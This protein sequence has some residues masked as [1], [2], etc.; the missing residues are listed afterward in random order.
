MLIFIETHKTCDF[1]GG[2]GPDPLSPP[3][4]KHLDEQAFSK[5]DVPIFFFYFSTK[6]Y[7]LGTLLSTQNIC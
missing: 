2:G 1:P 3:Q 5:E 4:D 6:T 7:V